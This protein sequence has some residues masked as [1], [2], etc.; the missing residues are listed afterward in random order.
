MRSLASLKGTAILSLLCL[1]APSQLV[2]EL[3]TW[4]GMHSI[5]QIEVTMVYFVPRDRE[6]LPDWRARVEYFSRRLEAFHAREFQ[7]QSRLTTRLPAEP[8]RSTK[9]TAQLRAGDGDHTFFQTLREVDETTQ[10]ARQR[11]EAYPI[12]L[13]LS[14]INWRPLDDFYRLGVVDGRLEF[15]GSLNDGE[16][17]PGAASGGARATYLADRGVGWGLVSGDGW[18]VP[19]RGTDCVVY[20]E[21]VGHPIG[22]PHPQPGDD[23]VMSL[24]QYRGWLSESSVELSQKLRLG[25]KPPA[26]NEDLSADL[27][28]VF[29]ALPQ[30]ATPRP[31]ESVY[32]RLDWPAGAKVRQ[33]QIR[34]QTDV[35]GPWTLVAEIPA[36][37]AP[38]EALLGQFDR[39]TPV[40]Y[41]VNAETQDGQAVEIWG[42]FQVRSR[43]DLIPP[44]PTDLA[45]FSE[46]SRTLTP[47]RDEANEVDLLA[48][49]DPQRDRV[50]G[51]WTLAD[52]RLESP[53]EYGARIEIPYQPPAEYELQVIAEPLDEPSGLI[54]GQLSG[55]NRFLVLVNYQIDGKTLSALENVNG[56]NV[57]NE[58]TVEVAY[59]KRGRPSHV[60]CT[61]RKTGVTVSVDGREAIAWQGDPASLSLGDYWKTPRD[62]VL[63]LGAYDC[64]YRFSRVTLLPL[65]GEGK[66]LASD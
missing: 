21:G 36:G 46:P 38:R 32:L 5:D 1:L 28:T 40:S 65:A 64:R 2:A 20:H 6:P 48:L 25:W 55:A 7:G 26:E 18:R 35:R 51:Q 12:L 27:F 17:F 8:F 52:R 41:R 60:A 13:V 4:D 10:F 53:K 47:P 22:L 33:A 3:K 31:N 15:E 29:R 59:F 11:G 42:Y 39:P 34:I 63:F 45:E 49:I 57:G 54:L 56:A 23:S 9:S 24:G 37:D 19:Y 66:S 62:N 44:P 16:H 43:P 58:T 30:P 61:V 14:E 50:Q